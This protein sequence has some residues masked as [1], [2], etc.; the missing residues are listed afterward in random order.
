MQTYSQFE[1]DVDYRSP[2]VLLV[3]D[4]PVAGSILEECLEQSG[5]EFHQA[6]SA[7]DAIETLKEIRPQIFLLD[8]M[9]DGMSGLQF[10]RHIRKQTDH[11]NTPVIMLTGRDDME[12][13]QDAFNS[14]AT[15]FLTKPINFQLVPHHIRFMLKAFQNEQHLAVA[16]DE[17]RSAEKTK[18]QFLANMSHELRTPLNAIIGFSELLTNGAKFQLPADK[19]SEYAEDI[20]NSGTHLLA[21]V[22]DVLDLA[23]VNAGSLKA[24]PSIVEIEEIFTPAL[25][26]VSVSRA[27][28]NI[29]IRTEEPVAGTHVEID[30]RLLRQILVNLLSNAIKFSQPN[31]VVRLG[32]EVRDD[33]D[34]IILVSDQ[35]IGIESD[36][37]TEVL[38]PFTQI[39][40][41]FSRGHEGTGL[42]LPI[43]KS[44]TELMGGKLSIDSQL[45]VG[46]T[47]KVS[48]PNAVRSEDV[49]DGHTSVKK[50]K[51][52]SL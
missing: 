16:L 2:T 7:E 9:L 34:L 17:A 28:R 26:L 45:D 36:K 43:A 1:T 49:G 40:D 50:E 3:E 30:V 48:F 29:D 18:D 12:V 4:D 44:F 11:A 22:N 35:G 32:L 37:I 24:E 13:I 15:S 52:A 38:K 21:I 20:Y 6:A 10:L 47:V 8:I 42:G 19:A 46:T 27:E 25:Q 41:A 5:Y 31:S 51:V 33:S 39:E 23:K 14:G